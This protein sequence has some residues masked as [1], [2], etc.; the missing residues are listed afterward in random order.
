VSEQRKLAEADREKISHLLN[1]QS[2]ENINLGLSLFE[3]TADVEDIQQIFTQQM[4]DKLIC[5]REPL[6]QAR[7]IISKCPITSDLFVVT[8]S[9]YGQ[10]ELSDAVAENLSKLEGPLCLDSLTGL[11]DTAAE[12]LSRHKGESLSLGKLTELSDVAAESLSKYEGNLSIGLDNLPES[13]AAILGKLTKKIAERFLADPDSVY[14]WG[15]TA[16]EDDAA[17]S[18]GKHEGELQLNGLT[19]LS[20]VAAESLSKHEGELQLNGLTSLS[21][22]AAESLSKHEGILDLSGLREISQAAAQYL[23][24]LDYPN[25][26]INT[27]LKYSLPLES[28]HWLLTPEDRFEE[29]LQ[30]KGKRNTQQRRNL[31]ELVC[32]RHEHFD[33]DTLIDQLPRKGNAGYV[34]RPTVY[35]TLAEFVDAGLLH[36]FQLDGRAV[37]ERISRNSTS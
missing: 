23:S 5:Q 15:F 18:L 26:H 36:K 9:R 20:D 32:S 12:F 33:A 37:Y 17:E 34:S 8:L 16:V 10:L 2:L 4:L 35:R 24:R 28:R 27:W 11:S 19:S 1:T 6:H 21:D 14:L 22:V 13:A 25:L 7:N 30:S 31:M 3:Q 29:Y